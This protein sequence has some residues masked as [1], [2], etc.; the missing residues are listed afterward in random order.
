MSK[1]KS[2]P[3]ANLA[4]LWRSRIV[5]SGKLPVDQVLF[6]PLNPKIHPTLQRD[7]L[8][9]IIEHVGY[10][11]PIIVNSRNGYLVDGEER[12]WLASQIQQET[13]QVIEMEVIYVDLSEEEHEEMLMLFDAVG[14]LAE[15][16]PTRLRELLVKN[17]PLDSYGERLRNQ[18]QIQIE[19]ISPSAP[20]EFPEYNESIADDVEFIVCPHCG[21]RFPK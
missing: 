15:P 3:I 7:T 4:P 10:I 8:R 11:A 1:K 19:K 6:H 5:S 13:G 16:D 2:E 21:Q 17:K 18:L 12:S 20:D 9:E 14:A